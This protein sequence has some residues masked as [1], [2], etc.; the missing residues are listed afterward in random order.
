MLM[1]N[2]KPL[3]R[4]NGFDRAIKDLLKTQIVNSKPNNNE[5]R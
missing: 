5:Q 4:C 2:K 1:K 3:P